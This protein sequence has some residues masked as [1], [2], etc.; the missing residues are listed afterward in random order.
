MI[1]TLQ[2][3]M[4]GNYAFFS[5]LLILCFVWQNY[6]YLSRAPQQP[7]NFAQHVQFSLTRSSVMSLMLQHRM[8]LSLGGI[9]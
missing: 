4:A 7:I 3:D 8:V 6:M 2:F 5:V 1:K 9:Y